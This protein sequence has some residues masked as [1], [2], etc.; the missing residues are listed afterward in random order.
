MGIL[1]NKDARGKALIR[2]LCCPRNPTK[3]NDSLRLT[4]ETAPEDF[5]ALYA[6]CAQDIVAEGGLSRACPDL[7]DAELSVWMLDQRINTYGVAID[8]VALDACINIVEQARV[9]YTAEL[10]QLTGGTV[11]TV[12]ELAKI[13]GWLAGRGVPLSSIDADHVAAALERDDLPADVR[14]VLAIRSSLGARSVKKLYS[15]RNRLCKDGRIRDLFAY[16]GADRTGRWAGRGPQP[17]NLP[18]SG[19]PSI[20]CP[21]CGR[22]HGA[23]LHTQPGVDIEWGAECMAAAIVDI[24]TLRLDIVEYYWGDAIAAV[25][26]CLRGL[27][28]AGPGYDLI[29]S[30]FSAIEAVVLAELAGESWRR[31]VFQ[32]HGKIYETSAS[33]ISGVPLSEILAYPKANGG[34]KH[35][36]RKLGKV[37]ELACFGANTQVLTYG[38]WKRIAD[39]TTDDRLHDGRGWVKHGGV[40]S[41]G[42]RG[43]INLGGVV[44]TPDHKFAGGSNTWIEARNLVSERREAWRAR[45]YAYILL[46]A[47]APDN[48]GIWRPYTSHAGNVISAEVYD[49]LNCGPRS[50]FVIR[51]EHGPL[52]AHNSGY[53]GW[54]NAWRQFGADAFLSDD[55]IKTAILKW[56]DES[57]AIVEFWGGQYRKH[58]DRWEFVPELY[59]IE[60]AVV[61]ALLEPG[62]CYSYRGITYGHDTRA[63]VLYCVLPSGRRLSYHKPRLVR[64]YDEMRRVHKYDISYMGHNSD[65]RKGPIGWM[66]INTYSGKLVENIVQAVAR[67]LLVYS[68]LLLDATGG[69]NIVLHVHDE[70]VA[71]VPEGEGD[72]ALFEKI[73]GTMPP[74]AQTPG[75]GAWPIRAAGGWVGKNYRK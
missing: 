1:V 11:K 44:V 24:K 75:S 47:N 39:I 50:R 13:Q 42:A 57:S 7:S 32:T 15:L 26:G 45:M 38:G 28:C 62:K 46:R 36:L 9:Q 34:T 30:D 22:I 64:V 55:E 52:I 71:E 53:G 10:Q 17:Q 63:D 73:M 4:P 18:N 58:P 8:R 37:G 2:K 70:V 65:Y 14:R 40:V 56:R 31:E 20:Q 12:D 48:L 66:R 23:Q 25:S 69:I 29:C 6:Y 72:V 51:T 16:C 33:K 54:I 68:M 74:W 5:A 60:G 49:I 43:V 61:M 67:D 21:H 41:R 3:T 27:F 19:P 35:P 59:G